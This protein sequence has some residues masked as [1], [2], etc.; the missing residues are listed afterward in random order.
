MAGTTDIVAFFFSATD[1][2][3]SAL[4]PDV[5]QISLV[6][7]AGQVLGGAIALTV[8]ASTSTG[9]TN[10]AGVAGVS[11]F[12]TAV[13]VSLTFKKVEKLPLVMS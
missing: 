3:I 10:L 13:K 2:L 6:S 9:L 4:D 5:N 7:S 8:D 1:G 12:V 11:G